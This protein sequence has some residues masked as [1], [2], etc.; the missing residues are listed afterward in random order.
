MRNCLTR[1][2]KEK[3]SD[4]L[5]SIGY[6]TKP[7]EIF[8]QQLK[9]YQIDVVADVR[10]VPFSKAFH[11]YHQDSINQHLLNNGIKYVYLGEELGPRS[12]NPD[13]Y[14]QC[15]QVQFS[16][17]MQSELFLNG[18]TR[19]QTGLSKGYKVALMCAEKDPANC[20]RST[21]IAYFLNHQ[22]QLDIPHIQH[23]GT[24]EQQNALEARLM[25][26]H[27]VEPDML[28]T[29]EECLKTAYELQLKKTSYIKPQ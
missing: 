10:S 6:A 27:E 3:M 21:L 22:R 12:K 28:T 5:F 20:H 25:Q 1:T 11:D 19:V 23:D 7:I 15:G 9:H 13:H 8:I 17:L 4:Q 24:L 2:N 18:I 29:L 26:I 16:Q 14:D